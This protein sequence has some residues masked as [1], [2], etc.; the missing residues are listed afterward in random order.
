MRSA[1]PSP[2]RTP[3]ITRFQSVSVAADRFIR[4]ARMIAEETAIAFTYNGSAH[5]VMMASPTDF[6]DSAVGF[7]L[8]EGIVSTV[9]E[10]SELK[11]V[12]SELGVELLMWTP[13]VLKS[14]YAERRRRL[15]G[16][17]GWGLCAIE[18]LGEASRPVPLIHRELCVLP[19]TISSAMEALP[20]L[21]VGDRQTST[22][23]TRHT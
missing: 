2:E 6:N 15:A 11:V 14:A 13:D 19:A 16:L 4:G 5:A 1:S 7:S 8:T 22:L 3:P 17:T 10:I 21:Q 9:S 18:S 20:S 12:R 23:R